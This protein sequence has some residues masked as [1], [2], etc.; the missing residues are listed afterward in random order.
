VAAAAAVLKSIAPT[1]PTSLLLRA[2]R[3]SGVNKTDAKATSYQT[4]RVDVAAATA[5]VRTLMAAG[6]DTTPP[7]NVAVTHKS[8]AAFIKSYFQQQWNVTAS[9]E[10]GVVDMCYNL[11]SICNQFV[12][13]ASTFVIYMLP[14]VEGYLTMYVRVRDAVGNTAAA[15]S[16]VYLDMHAPVTKWHQVNGGAEWVNT[17]TVEMTNYAY[18]EGGA[19]VGTMWYNTIREFAD[20]DALPYSNRTMWTIPGADDTID[21]YF[22]VADR[23]GNPTTHGCA[24]I[25]W[26][27]RAWSLSFRAGDAPACFPCDPIKLAIPPPIKI[28]MSRPSALISRRPQAAW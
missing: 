8:G 7:T 14:E 11:S 1:A 18:D 28:G 21:I 16:T 19:G 13:F 24:P 2:L 15:E 26:L 23:A 25:W 3:E 27:L 4:P 10:S 22:R 9:D 5:L 12:P 17:R 20:E 6:N